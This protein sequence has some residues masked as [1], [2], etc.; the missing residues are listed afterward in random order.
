MFH[1]LQLRWRSSASEKGGDSSTS[2]KGGDSSKKKFEFTDAVLD[3][4]L[5][6]NDKLAIHKRAAIQGAYEV[7]LHNG[8]HPE[9]AFKVITKYPDLVR[10]QPKTLEYALEY[11]RGYQF[12]HSQYVQLF[13]QCPELLEFDDE[14]ELR[15]R[16]AELKVLAGTSKNIWRLLMASPDIMTESPK[17]IQAK[18]DYLFKVMKVDVSDAVKSGVFSHSLL[19]LKCRHMLLVRLGIYK[20]KAKNA[21]PL[22]SNKNPRVHR[23]ADTSDSM[24]ARKICGISIGELNAFN[25]LYRRELEQQREDEAEDDTDEDT[26]SDYDSEDESD[27]EFDPTEKDEYDPRDRNRYKRHLISKTKK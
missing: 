6:T 20:E 21:S 3:A 7:F 9:N 25:A 12:S 13:L 16:F 10:K 22:D 26:D 2:E 5:A 27:D 14:N 19:R 4:E 17:I 18:A 11:W 24:F 1:Q 8:F 23:I 15:T